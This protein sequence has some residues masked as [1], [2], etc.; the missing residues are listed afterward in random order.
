MKIRFRTVT[1][2][3]NTYSNSTSKISVNILKQINEKTL[4]DNNNTL[5][6]SYQLVENI[7]KLKLSV[8]LHMISR[9]FL[10][11]SICKT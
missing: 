3:C 11:I 8:L 6:N 2:G 7:N 5:K 9:T 4:N 10:T 1:I